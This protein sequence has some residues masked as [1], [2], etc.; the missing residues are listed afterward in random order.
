VYRHCCFYLLYFGNKN[1]KRK[2]KICCCVVF[3]TVTY[4]WNW[5][6][7]WHTQL[8]HYAHI[9]ETLA[10][11]FS[12]PLTPTPFPP[13][14]RALNLQHVHNNNTLVYIFVHLRRPTTKCRS[15]VGLHELDGSGPAC[16][17]CLL[18]QEGHRNLALAVLSKTVRWLWSAI[19]HNHNRWPIVCWSGK[20][21]L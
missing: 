1:K 18:S 19:W 17:P 6:G 20:C 11:N 4:D 9:A 5:N 7:Y 10:P 2:E 13:T 12:N 8:T 16:L 14:H 3:Y 21:C 15:R